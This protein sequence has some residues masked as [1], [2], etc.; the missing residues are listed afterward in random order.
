[1]TL[2]RGKLMSRVDFIGEATQ[3]TATRF[4]QFG[5]SVF[6]CD[7]SPAHT[8]RPP[9]LLSSIVRCHLIHSLGVAGWERERRLGIRVVVQV[10]KRGFEVVIIEQLEDLEPVLRVG[11]KD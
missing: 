10:G 4:E 1:M 7:A 8:C 9:R 6:R 5:G 11:S 3:K 2:P